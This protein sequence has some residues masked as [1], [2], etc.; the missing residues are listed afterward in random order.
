MC[1]HA[2]RGYPYFNMMG[3][4]TIIYVL[5]NAA[6]RGTIIYILQH[7]AGRGT[8]ILFYITLSWRLL[9]LMGVWPKELPEYARQTKKVAQQCVN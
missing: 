3:R 2:L 9:V 8:I 1:A 4:G 6:G 5:Q 7:V